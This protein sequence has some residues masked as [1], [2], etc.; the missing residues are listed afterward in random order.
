M[1]AAPKPHYG[2]DNFYCRSDPADAPAKGGVVDGQ[3]GWVHC[4]HF[5]PVSDELNALVKQWDA[6][7]D[8]RRIGTRS[9]T[10]GAAFDDERPLLAPRLP[11]QLKCR[12]SIRA[13]RSHDTPTACRNRHHRS[14][15]MPYER[16]VAAAFPAASSSWK[17]IAAGRHRRRRPAGRART[18]R[19]SPPADPNEEPSASTDPVW[20]HDP[21]SRARTVLRDNRTQALNCTI[22]VVRAV[23]GA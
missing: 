3:I 15:S 13:A 8:A 20:G 16:T 9:R 6:I 22:I 5:V 14:R 10:V 18:G 2:L 23:N 11:L 7:D 21:P 12:A 1:D 17:N 4:N 19:R